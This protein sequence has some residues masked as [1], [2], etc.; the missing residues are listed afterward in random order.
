MTIS[1]AMP[2]HFCAAPAPLKKDT[3][4]VPILA[5]IQDCANKII[6]TRSM[7]NEPTPWQSFLCDTILGISESLVAEI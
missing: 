2:V 1:V 7:K 5:R 3:G 4:R 6:A